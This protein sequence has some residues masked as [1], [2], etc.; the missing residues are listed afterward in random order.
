GISELHSAVSR[1]KIPLFPVKFP[2]VLEET[3]KVLEGMMPDEIGSRSALA[4]LCLSDELETSKWAIELSGMSGDKAVAAHQEKARLFFHKPLDRVLAMA[5]ENSANKI[6]A[7][8][9]YM[10]PV[11]STPLMERIGDFAREPVTGILILLAVMIALYYIVGQ[12]AAGFLVDF[13]VKDFFGGMI[14]PNLDRVVAFIPYAFI[15]EMI[16]GKFGLYPMGL[17][18]ALGLV[19]P[20]IAAFYFTFGFIEDSGYFSRLSI[21]LDRLF[22]KLG[23]N[24]KALLPIML[25]FSCV[26]MAT[27]ATRVLETKKERLIAIFLL[28]LGIPCSAKLSVI[29]VV[30]ARVSFGAF[31]TVF[32]VVFSLMVITGLILSKML[33]A[34]A[35]HFIMDVPPIRIPSLRNV[36]K[37]TY[38]RSVHFLKEAT[39]LFFAGA[40]SLFILD[41]IGFL[42]L[43]ERA[44]SPVTKGFLGL[45]E[46]F[47]ES[48]IM[49]F[50]RGEAGIAILKQMVDAGTMSNQQLVIAMIVTILFIPC[51]TNF[52]LII[53]EHGSKS[54]F[55]IITSVTACAILTG[56]AMNHILKFFN[57]VF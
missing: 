26:S 2:P 6:F 57:I 5:R 29:L 14:G 10:I 20:I 22:K 19:L 12:F 37:Q 17:V 30:L 21:L 56:G 38:H 1:A 13:L 43:V 48:L 39:P 50:I 49:G 32:G 45:P 4:A 33:P 42:A 18:P 51:V 34:E 46:Q 41:K 47:A 3:I 40:I 8:S 35:S 54:A 55:A 16:T 44:L 7:E 15:R 23:M 53:K 25:G 27:I 52:L 31:M 9:A 36:L 24:G 11:R 28:S